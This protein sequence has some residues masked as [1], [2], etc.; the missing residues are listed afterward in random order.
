M[1]N[2]K[3]VLRVCKNSF[4]KWKGNL[5]VLIVF[6][7]LAVLLFYSTAGA[8]R[9]AVEQNL[10]V[11]PWI[12]PFL[13][14][15]PFNRILFFLP[16]I[17]L[18]SDAPFFDEQFPYLCM[19]SSRSVWAKGELLYIAA[20]SLLFT[21]ALYVFSVLFFIP[22]LG[23][24]MD[25]GKILRMLSMGSA[26]SMEFTET[27]AS[28]IF[29]K[30]EILTSYSP[31]AATLLSVLIVWCL[32]MFLGLVMFV[33]NLRF[34][35][36]VG[37]A[38]ASLLVCFSFFASQFMHGTRA[39]MIFYFSPVSWSNLADIQMGTELR[40][41]LG[42]VIGALLVLIAVLSLLAAFLIK[43]KDIEVLPE[44]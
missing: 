44:V 13:F 30:P 14:G 8:R 27:Y 38:A 5:R 23:F 21:L 1:D 3:N 26:M 22:Y 43:H 24:S 31:F 15:V 28:G 36:G 20:S 17:F 25:W 11:T 6:L 10:A 7:L 18:F 40:P 35:R 32:C 37:A 4:L 16:L 29:I 9:L 12:F 2:G 33:L 41:P 42:Y 39:G 19:R 34:P